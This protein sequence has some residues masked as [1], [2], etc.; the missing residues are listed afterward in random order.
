MDGSP[1]PSDGAD[2]STARDN[3]TP[4]GVSSVA[5]E[6]GETSGAGSLAEAHALQGSDPS[7]APL[8]TDIRAEESEEMMEVGAEDVETFESAA[9]SYRDPTRPAPSDEELDDGT[10]FGPGSQ[11]EPLAASL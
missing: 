4:P 6:G 8:L 10:Y 11:Y 7:W 2:M 1:R 3:D 9:S 5:G